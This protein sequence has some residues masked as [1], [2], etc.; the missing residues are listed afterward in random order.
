[1]Y[2]RLTWTRSNDEK[3]RVGD[4]NGLQKTKEITL[5]Q[6]DGLFTDFTDFSKEWEVRV[7][8]W[9]VLNAKLAALV[10]R[11]TFVTVFV[12]VTPYQVPPVE[13]C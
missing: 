6:N 7:R 4:S 9:D 12:Y 11:T 1:M 13:Q 5:G 8:A 10:R 2:R 3:L